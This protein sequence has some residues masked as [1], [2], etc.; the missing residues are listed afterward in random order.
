[1]ISDLFIK[2]MHDFL[3]KIF[4]WVSLPSQNDRKLSLYIGPDEEIEEL[5]NQEGEPFISLQPAISGTGSL[6]GTILTV[7]G[8]K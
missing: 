8:M 1:M 5:G 7:R 4:S 2:T 6:F 3:V